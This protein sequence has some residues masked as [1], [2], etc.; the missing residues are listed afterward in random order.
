MSSA[1]GLSAAKRRRGGGSAPPS[2]SN[3]VIKKGSGEPP[4]RSVPGKMPPVPV[5]L[6]VHEERIRRLEKLV[7]DDGSS[8]AVDSH[9]V[10]WLPK[11][12]FLQVVQALHSE[13]GGLKQMVTDMQSSVLSNASAIKAQNVKADAVAEVASELENVALDDSKST[14]KKG[15]GA[16]ASD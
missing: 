4:R 2:S 8:I 1:A 11:E 12:E 3:T 6:H 10:E 14:K 16:N 13:I 7:P 9:G 15:K 5:V